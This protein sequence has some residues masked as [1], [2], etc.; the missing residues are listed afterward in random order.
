MNRPIGI[1]KLVSLVY[2]RVDCVIFVD[3]KNRRETNNWML[4]IESR[5]LLSSERTSL[6]FYPIPSIFYSRFLPA[7]LTSFA[8]RA[9]DAPVPFASLEA[10]LSRISPP[11]TTSPPLRSHPLTNRSPSSRWLPPRDSYPSTSRQNCNQRSNRYHYYRS[12]RD[13]ISQFTF[14]KLPSEAIVTAIE[15]AISFLLKWNKLFFQSSP[16]ENIEH[17]YQQQFYLCIEITHNVHLGQNNLDINTTI[18]ESAPSSITGEW[19]S[20]RDF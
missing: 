9:F 1:G 14:L 7:T 10:P 15:S 3:K 19:N 16:N 17:K 6:L 12:P 8:R 2:I 13:A 18:V 5:Q 20:M 11:L 4:A